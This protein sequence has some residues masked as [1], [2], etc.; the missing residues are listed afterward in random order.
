MKTK[1]HPLSRQ[2]E[3]VIKELGHEILI[4]DLKINKAHCLNETSALV[5]NLCDGKKSVSEISRLITGKLRSSVDEEFVFYALEQL[6]KQNLL[7]LN[8]EVPVNLSGLSRR[9]VIR[10]VGLTSVVALPLVS[11]LVA[12]TAAHAASGGAGLNEAC[13][14]T[15]G[16][17]GSCASGFVC[18]P[19]IL[20][21]S[22]NTCQPI[23]PGTG[24]CADV[25]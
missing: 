16:T 15:I 24:A 2:N 14:G 4:Y 19:D 9:E 8:E 1:Q 22:P 25:V 17:Q 13:T 12:P 6:Q 11:S 20:V 7:V 3:L 21:S 18:C 10:R 5:W 23:D